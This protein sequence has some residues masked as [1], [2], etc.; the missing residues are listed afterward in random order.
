MASLEV[1]LVLSPEEYSF[2][3][4]YKSNLFDPYL[5]NE[6]FCGFPKTPVK[7]KFKFGTGPYRTYSY[8]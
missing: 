7:A 2:T 4:F 3:G 1:L 5:L 8:G 6:L